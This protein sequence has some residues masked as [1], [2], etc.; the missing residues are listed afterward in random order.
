MFV[1]FWCNSELIKLLLF[2]YDSLIDPFSKLSVFSLINFSLRS[3]TFILKFRTFNSP[4][5][6]FDLVFFTSI[7]S[8]G[9]GGNDTEWITGFAS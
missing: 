4:V 5:F 2:A 3:N 9:S 6:L 7:F 1:I 8:N